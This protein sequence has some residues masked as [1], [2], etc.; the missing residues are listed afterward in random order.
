LLIIVTTSVFGLLAYG[1]VEQLSHRTLP[2]V[3]CELDKQLAVMVLVKVIFNFFVSLPSATINVTVLIP[4]INND[5]TV[6][7]IIKKY[8][9]SPFYIYI[10]ASQ[11]FQLQLFFV[12]FKIH[13]E[14]AKNRIIRANQ[15][16]PQIDIEI[17]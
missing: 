8:F 14:R 4:N 13:L 1:N 9:S 3:R 17:T 16:V 12:L 15:L 11:R 7:L 6:D 10:C 2:L 5:L